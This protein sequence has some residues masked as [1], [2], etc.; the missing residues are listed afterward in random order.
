MTTAREFIQ[1]AKS[2][3]RCI[4]LSQARELLDGGSITLLDVREKIEHDA[5]HIEDSRHI[6]RGVLEMQIE[7]HPDFQDKN[8]SVIIYCKSGGRSAL[9]AATLQDMGFTNLYSLDG[10]FD[11]W[12]KDQ[13]VP[14]GISD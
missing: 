13:A 10:G 9:A 2:K 11:G 7:N 3:V 6:S 5:G 14:E 12:S 4:D 1:E 8:A